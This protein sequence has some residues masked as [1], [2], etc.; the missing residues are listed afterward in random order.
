[1]KIKFIV[2]LKKRETIKRYNYRIHLNKH[3]QIIQ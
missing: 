3:I 1:M 2:F